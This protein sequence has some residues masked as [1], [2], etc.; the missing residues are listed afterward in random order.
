MSLGSSRRKKRKERK[1]RGK[2]DSSKHTVFAKK[3]KH[4]KY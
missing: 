4:Q 2:G 3:T 1:G